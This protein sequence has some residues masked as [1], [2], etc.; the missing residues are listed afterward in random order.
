MIHRKRLAALVAAAFLIQLAVPLARLAITYKALAAG[1]APTSTGTLAT[2]FA[3]VPMFL[4]IRFGRI[5]DRGHLG[6]SVLV[7]SLIIAASVLGLLLTS[8]TLLELFVLASVLGVGQT[9]LFSGLQMVILLASTRSHR[10]RILGNYLLATSLGGA[11]A[12]LVVSLAGTSD[13]GAVAHIL[14]VAATASAG[15]LVAS[16]LV[17]YP[18]IN[19]PLRTAAPA[20]RPILELLRV[21]GLFWIVVAGSTYATMQDLI[22]IYVPVLGLDRAIGLAEVGLL[23]SASQIASVASRA[24]YGALAQALGRVR[25]MLGAALASAA[26]FCIVALPLPV[27][28]LFVLLPLIGFSLGTGATATLSLALDMAPADSRSTTMAL[29]QL[30]NRIVLFC[31]PLAFNALGGL[32][33][34]QAIF[35]GM[36]AVLG[37]TGLLAGHGASGRGRFRPYRPSKGP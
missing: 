7:G 30:S 18:R 13:T 33:G 24:S 35:V 37:A 19:Q 20:H 1:L 25:L 23:L 31:F 16:A 15:C 26:C 34:V 11:L 29:R 5:N 9:L 32:F 36:G 14:A 2:A 3:L 4:A 12:P 17:L 22:L 8:G 21:R 6:T 27:P 10:D 28:A